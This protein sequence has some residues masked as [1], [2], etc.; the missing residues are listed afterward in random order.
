MSALNDSRGPAGRPLPGGKPYAPQL[1]GTP[2][3]LLDDTTPVA[4]SNTGGALF[5]RCFKRRESVDD[6]GDDTCNH[7]AA[8]ATA[9]D[10]SASATEERVRRLQRD[11]RRHELQ[12]SALL[13]EKHE[14]CENLANV[15]E[16]LEKVLHKIRLVPTHEPA[17][18]SPSASPPVPRSG[19]VG[20]EDDDDAASGGIAAFASTLQHRL[21]GALQRQQDRIYDVLADYRQ[22][23]E[24]NERESDRRLRVVEGAVS[25][26]QSDIRELQR[27]TGAMSEEQRRFQQEVRQS[28]DVAAAAAAA[29]QEA[30]RAL[31]DAAGDTRGATVTRLLGRLQE[32]VVQLRTDAEEL[33]GEQ[34]Q[35][36]AE[37]DKQIRAL[38][39]SQHR[40]DAVL[41]EH[42]ALITRLQNQDSLESSFHEV[43]DWLGDLEKRMI[44]RGELLQWTESL[45]NEIHQLRRVA[46]EP[47]PHTVKSTAAE[48]DT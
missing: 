42:S 5:Q 31:P 6:D 34:A 1:Q 38:L 46:G 48:H 8:V 18:P 47:L 22:Q 35:S 27:V 10:T 13:R 19:S 39:S 2:S 3:L 45:Q 40:A 20:V 44:S 21:N 7:N 43:K 16:Q 36:G 12:I 32:E 23:I 24:K 41:H 26:M 4:A 11:V 15:Y 29:Q 9:L 37:L 30:R 17:A 33:R 28:I 25:Q 14:H